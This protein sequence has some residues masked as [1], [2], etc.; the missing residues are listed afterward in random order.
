MK[1]TKL[2]ESDKTLIAATTQP[3]L[4][5]QLISSV[6]QQQQPKQDPIVP[7]PGNV[8]FPAQPRPR[9][10]GPFCQP[11]HG[12]PEP[13]GPR[14]AISNQPRPRMPG[15]QRHPEPAAFSG[16]MSMFSGPSASSKPATSSFFSVP[17]TSF[18]KSS[19]P[20]APAQPQQQ[21]S[22]FFNLPT[23]LQTDSLTGDLFGLF[24]GTESA[25]SDET[26]LP[27]Q[28]S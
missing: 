9:M 16:F 14:P 10:A 6:Q 3:S 19:P 24:K 15:S 11:R 5:P 8:G 23:S 7:Q 17:Q 28:R 21:K 4:D 12:M 25:I 22:S 1:I 20:S 2:Q 27:E 18:F 26:K 13:R